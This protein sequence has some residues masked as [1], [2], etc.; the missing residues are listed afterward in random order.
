MATLAAR[1]VGLDIAGIDLVA[2]DIS[3]PLH[4]QGGAIIEV[5]AS[6]GLLAHLKPANG[7]PRNVGEAIVDHLFAQEE[8][9]R[10]P[11]VGITGKH[12]TT[13]ASRLIAWLLQISGKKV[14]LTCADGLFVNGRLLPRD[15]FSDW[16]TGER[17]LLN[18]NVEAA[19]FESSARM[20]LTEGLAY[21][22]CA[23]GVVTDVSDFEELSEFYI[24][25][26]DKLYGV[27]RTQVDV[28]LPSG[29]A[30]LNAADEQVVDMARLCD[31]QV[32]FYGVDEHLAAIAA[33]R[34]D[35]ER[36]VFQ[37]ADCIVMAQGHDEVASLPLSPLVPPEAVLA[38]IAAGWALGLTPDL[39]GAGLRTFNANPKRI[40]H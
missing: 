30:V 11:I 40:H 5:N 3:R 39:I 9:G 34:Q 21:D 1:V 4:E 35:S 19:V 29:V 7:E 26:S 37:R 31:G 25:S 38:A 36:V 10:M 12:G 23:V 18:K 2:A 24:E 16:E 15:G 32:I 27:L 8:S 6:P 17:L 20:I 33:H 28:I 14:G 22:K 13:M